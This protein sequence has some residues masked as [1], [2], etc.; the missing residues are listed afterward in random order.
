MPEAQYRKSTV[1]RRALL[2]AAEDARVD[3]VDADSVVI[4][5][6][7]VVDISPDAAC[8]PIAAG[9]AAAAAVV[10]SITDM[11][12]EPDGVGRSAAAPLLSDSFRCN[13]GCAKLWSPL[14][15]LARVAALQNRVGRE[16]SFSFSFACRTFHLSAIFFS[17]SL[18]LPEKKSETRYMPLFRTTI[19][20]QPPPPKFYFCNNTS[21]C[22]A[23]FRQIFWRKHILARALG[24]QRLFLALPLSLLSYLSS[25]T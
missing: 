23:H 22:C 5:V 13:G 20:K 9:A 24:S 1:T 2:A 14:S 19:T 7:I 18:F 6:G 4:V 17:W 10:P 15:L 16:L 21:F 25:P 11:A 3:V 8:V 12:E